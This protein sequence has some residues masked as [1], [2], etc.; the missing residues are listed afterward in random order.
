[1]PL[2]FIK[3]SAW[4]ITVSNTTCYLNLTFLLL[5]FVY[6][7]SLEWFIFSRSIQF[8]YLMNCFRFL[9]ISSLLLT[10]QLP[11][12]CILLFRISLSFFSLLPWNIRWSTVCKSCLH[13]RFGLTTIFSRC[14]IEYFHGRSWF[15][16]HLDLSLDS[17]PVF[18]P[19][20][21]KIS[22]IIT[23]FFVYSHWLCHLICFL[24]GYPFL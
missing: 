15:L 1:M 12:L 22:L 9:S 19:H 14:K 6:I 18:F 23:A 24:T 13:G 17:L 4:S 2:C 10:G 21:G 11:A 3:P 8:M 7:C 16:L 20:L 5:V